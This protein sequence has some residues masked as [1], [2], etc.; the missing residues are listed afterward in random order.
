MHTNILQL[1][2]GFSKPGSMF[3]ITNNPTQSDYYREEI[4]AIALV[5]ATAPT[6]ALPVGILQLLWITALNLEN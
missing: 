3:F 6:G 1:E 4:E 5:S 2:P